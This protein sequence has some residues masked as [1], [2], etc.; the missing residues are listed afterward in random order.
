VLIAVVLFLAVSQRFSV[1]QRTRRGDRD[2]L[3]AAQRR[4]HLKLWIGLLD[5]SA[6][7]LPG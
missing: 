6:P 7:Y 4:Y 2:A 5:E 3:P 1:R